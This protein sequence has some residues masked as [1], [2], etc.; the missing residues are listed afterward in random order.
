MPRALLL[1]LLLSC[2]A[3]P[4]GK[5]AP[6]A[7]GTGEQVLERGGELPVPDPRDATSGRD[8]GT[9]FAWAQSEVPGSSRLQAA[10]A[11]VDALA[12]AE[13]LKIVQVDLTATAEVRSSSDNGRESGSASFATLEKA[14][15]VVA[16]AAPPQHAWVKLKRDGALILRVYA[17]AAVPL[18]P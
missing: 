8:G 12:R 10:L 13:L 6:T 11:L 5:P 7:E 18:H 9:L 3:A 16:Q 14:R 2:A 4:I 1:S 15:G 17:R